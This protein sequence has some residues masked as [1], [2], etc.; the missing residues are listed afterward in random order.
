MSTKDNTYTNIEKRLYFLSD[1]VDN[2]SIGQLT[3][4]ILYQIAE[5]DEQVEEA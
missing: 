1:D 5:D 2:S 4:S 3:W